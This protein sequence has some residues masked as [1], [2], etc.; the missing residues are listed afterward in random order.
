MK[1]EL[2]ASSQIIRICVNDTETG[3]V[4]KNRFNKDT[5]VQSGFNQNQTVMQIKQVIDS[6]MSGNEQMT[7]QIGFAKGMSL[8]NWMGY[9]GEGEGEEIEL[10]NMESIQIKDRFTEGNDLIFR[11]TYSLFGLIYTLQLS[12]V[13]ITESEKI[14]TV[15]EDLKI[16]MQKR[17]ERIMEE[18]KIL[19]GDIQ[20]RESRIK[21]EINRANR[22]VINTVEKQKTN[23]Q[24]E[25]KAM[26]REMRNEIERLKESHKK[27]IVSLKQAK[28]QEMQ[29]LK[30]E[31]QRLRI[32]FTKEFEEI[33]HKMN[34][35][36]STPIPV[37]KSQIQESKEKEE[38][39][40]KKQSKNN[41]KK[42]KNGN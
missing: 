31:I 14:T 15:V 6:A 28:I 32:N 12:Y 1:S 21:M 34:S 20:N 29:V 17:E 13:E 5:L 40:N 37:H 8:T 11:I 22:D 42:K 16:E 25:I 18:F 41:I 9:K 3:K 2:D 38:E 4:F 35:K 36:I 26:K 7:C 30:D 23:L 10:E 19:K 27:E 39:K 33:K 24:S